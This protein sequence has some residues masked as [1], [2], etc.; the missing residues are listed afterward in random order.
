MRQ[1]A[2]VEGHSDLI[3]RILAQPQQTPSDVFS[4]TDVWLGDTD[5]WG[6]DFD[7]TLAMYTESLHNFIYSTA[8]STLVSRHRYPALMREQ[9]AYQPTFAARGVFYDSAHGTLIKLDATQRVEVAFLGRRQ[10]TPAEISRRYPGGG[11]VRHDAVLSMRF[12][13]DHFCIGEICL[14]ADVVDWLV[15]AGL[16]FDA[17]MIFDDVSQAVSEVHRSGSLY[18]E[19]LRDP[20]RY[21]QPNAELLPFLRRLRENGKRAFI[22]TNSPFEFVNGVMLHL[23]G[24][25]WRHYLDLIITQAHKPDWFTSS[26]P[27]R[28]VATESGRV[29]WGRVTKL[30]GPGSGHVAA[31]GAA[32]YVGGSMSSLI[33][34]TGWD[35]RVLYFGDHVEADMRDPRRFGWRTAMLLPEVANDVAVQNTNAYRVNLGKLLEAKDFLANIY[36]VR[37]SADPAARS[38]VRD[39]VEDE[40]ETVKRDTRALFGTPFGSLFS[41][42]TQSSLF[43]LRVFRWTDM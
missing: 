27:F 2:V 19:I 25:G 16:T 15:R 42:D 39:H 40:M 14:L 41:S 36:S 11:H 23:L 32:V 30:L 18:K 5:I 38:A 6:F 37:R 31:D 12:L 35:R 28:R 4:C 10:L 22:L 13:A 24:H 29:D 8:L 1:E 3:A 21:V 20:S 17:K 34:A 33:E 43:G 7:Y 9:L 26:R